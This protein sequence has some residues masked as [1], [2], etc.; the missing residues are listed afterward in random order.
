MKHFFCLMVN[1]SR[2]L[3]KNIMVF[4]TKKTK[5]VKNLLIDYTQRSSK[6][7]NYFLEWESL[8]C[9]HIAILDAYMYFPYFYKNT[10]FLDQLMN[11]SFHLKNID[12][13]ILLLELFFHDSS[14]KFDFDLNSPLFGSESKFTP[15]FIYQN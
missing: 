15:A 11:Y 6:N 5:H 7:R 3:L 8:N 4:F 14:K 10:D 13:N 9:R 1:I 12:I 2:N